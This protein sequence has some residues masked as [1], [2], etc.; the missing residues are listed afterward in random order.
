MTI[1]DPY[2]HMENE[3]G[4]DQNPFP[5]EAISNKDDEPWAELYS[6]E[7]AR[8]AASSFAAACA[9]APPS[10]SCGR[11]APAPTPDSARPG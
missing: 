9:A 10:A 8:S 4:L 2:V 3:W 7:I 6:A 1:I 11:W 5:A